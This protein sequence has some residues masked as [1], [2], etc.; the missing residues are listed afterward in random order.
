MVASGGNSTN[1]KGQS[2][3]QT[4]V[5]ANY[6]ANNNTS[7]PT[8]QS[9]Y[10]HYNYNQLD[11]P[12]NQTSATTG[13]LSISQTGTSTAQESKSTESNSQSK[14]STQITSTREVVQQSA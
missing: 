8:Q 7:Y 5:P 6:P 12:E 14:A 1:S 13:T 9:Y 4:Q 2:Y 11:D 10:G 3:Q